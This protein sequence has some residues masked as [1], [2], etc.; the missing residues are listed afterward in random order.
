MRKL[1]LAALVVVAWAV[2]VSIVPARASVAGSG[3]ILVPGP[4]SKAVGGVTELLAPCLP[5]DPLQGFDGF[6][7]A[8]PGTGGH[9]ATLASDP[10]RGALDLDVYFYDASC[11]IIT[12]ARDPNAYGMATPLT[13][14]ERGTIP[15]A[16][17][18]A[19]VDLAAGANASFTF[20]VS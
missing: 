9:A 13:A 18:W 2:V 3:T 15:S 5:G 4:S 16:A 7:L 8:I 1:A 20:T 11:R 12:A 10:T 6:W 17:A 19:V 14:S